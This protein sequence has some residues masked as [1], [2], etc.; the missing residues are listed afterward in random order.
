MNLQTIQKRIEEL[1]S[2]LLTVSNDL[3]FL[4]SGS[5]DRQHAVVNRLRSFR[6]ISAGDILRFSE[7]FQDIDGDSVQAGEYKV[8]AVERE[9][10]EGDFD[11]L[12]NIG[13]DTHSWLDFK[14]IS[15]SQ[16]VTKVGA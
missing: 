8:V 2:E 9:A 13:G 6:Q 5:V 1:T 14:E 11:V 4:I 15:S 12:L 16:I 10:Y 3:A 7:E